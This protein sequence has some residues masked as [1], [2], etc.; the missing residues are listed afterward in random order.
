MDLF[1]NTQTLTPNDR[2]FLQ[3]LVNQ[4]CDA[5]CNNQKREFDS[6]KSLA[7]DFS[8]LK[9]DDLGKWIDFKAVKWT[10]TIA[11]LKQY[12]WISANVDEV[13]LRDNMIAAE[14]FGKKA[15]VKV[16]W[17]GPMYYTGLLTRKIGVRRPTEFINCVFKKYG[18]EK[19][20]GCINNR[21]I[22]LK[23]NLC[24]NFIRDFDKLY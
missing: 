24:K 8:T 7:K 5:I 6:K 12:G 18:V 15:A 14:T 4:I 2:E 20:D 21:K 3:G 1:D 13:M 11:L 16:D 10:E 17:L 23:A 22:M 19:I 9:V